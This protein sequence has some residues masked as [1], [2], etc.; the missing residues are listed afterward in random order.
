MKAIIVQFQ[1]IV[2]KRNESKE[3]MFRRAPTI[4]QTYN[5]ISYYLQFIFVTFYP[6]SSEKRKVREDEKK[7]FH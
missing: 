1:C 5:Y 4:I 6:Y 3:V 7:F 2:G